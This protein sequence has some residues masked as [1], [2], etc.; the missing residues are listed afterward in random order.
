MLRRQRLLAHLVDGKA[1]LVVDGDLAKQL[2]ALVFDLLAYHTVIAL[3]KRLDRFVPEII[4]MV[5]H[6]IAIA[7]RIPIRH[8]FLAM[9]RKGR[10]QDAI[11]IERT[12][13]LPAV[14]QRKAK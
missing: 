5:A 12:Y 6:T 14:L 2:I 13:R 11:G 3:F 10:I 9:Q 8:R 7:A 1:W 4:E